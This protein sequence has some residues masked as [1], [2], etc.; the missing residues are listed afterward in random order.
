MCEYLSYDWIKLVSKLLVWHHD[1]L[2][3]GVQRR[4]HRTENQVHPNT[5]CQMRTSWHCVDLALAQPENQQGK[6]AGDVS[7]LT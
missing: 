4:Y 2:N 7:S 1:S 3:P 5:H 6:A